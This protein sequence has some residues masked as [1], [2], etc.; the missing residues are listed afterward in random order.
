MKPLWKG[1]IGFGLVNIPVRLF[2]AV[3]EHE[4][5]LDMLDKRDNSNIHYKR[6]N[7][8]T[9]RD[10]PWKDIVKGYKLNGRYVVLTDNDFQNASPEKSQIIGIK[11]FIK[12]EEIDTMLYDKA[13]Y[14]EPGDAG[15]KAYILLRDA[16]KKSQKAALG[17]F[18]LRNKEHL[19]VLKNYDRVIVLQTLRYA[20]QIKKPTDI[21]IPASNPTPGE[22]KMALNLVNQLTAKKANF[23]KYKD[24]YTAE[25]LSLIKKKSKGAKIV[26]PK[27]KV[28]HRR[29]SDLAEQLK[30]SLASGK[31]RAS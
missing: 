27:L 12:T 5:D 17:S 31:K 8:N 19:C 13:Y 24:H 23:S 14:L 28:V 15:K 18:V 4:L 30:A 21:S 6:V 1:A 16:L 11:E 2:S 29:S 26:A 10:V 25:L 3:N 20:Q 9:G 22:M 7:E